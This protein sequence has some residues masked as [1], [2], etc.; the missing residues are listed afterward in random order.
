MAILGP[1]SYSLA[2][3]LF[4]ALLLLVAIGWRRRRQS[5]FLILACFFSVLWA[6]AAAITSIAPRLDIDYLFVLEVLRDAAWL[7]FLIAV[8]DGAERGLVSTRLRLAAWGVPAL[9]L[10]AGLFPNISGMAPRELMVPAAILLSLFGLLLVEQVYRNSDPL[11]RRPIAFLT[12]AVGGIFAYDLFL[13]SSA[14][15]TSSIDG[16][17]WA[18]RGF[19]NALVVPLL[20]VA[21]RR[22]RDW[23]VQMFVSRQAVSFSATLFGAGVYLLLMS[24]AGYY[25]KSVGGDWGSLAQSIFFF[26]TVVL[27][28]FILLSENIRRRIRVFIAKHFYENKYDYR[29]EWL[30]LAQTLYSSH[31]NWTLHE[32][33]IRALAQ[34]MRAESGVLWLRGEGE[35]NDIHPCA[36]WNVP[37]RAD[38]VEVA[39]SRLVT[40]LEL[41]NWVIDSDENHKDPDIYDGLTLPQWLADGRSIIVPLLLDRELLGFV[42]LQEV[43]AGPRLR[44]TIG[45]AC[46]CRC[47]W[48]AP[49]TIACRKGST[50]SPATSDTPK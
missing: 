22:N 46:C 3:L 14:L 30:R 4:F 31:E 36:A 26:A 11:T 40:F 28:A 8:L 18:S 37:L 9:I 27:L 24:L 41:K 5:G 32:R 23:P 15:L 16:G 34:I 6:A 45:Q 33:S 50:R 35:D 10:A 48:P 21:A 49:T 42:V 38:I 17:I 44:S 43:P 7:Q 12:I 20:A 25:I 19:A 29:E 39:D 1:I 2:A 47:R 13:Y